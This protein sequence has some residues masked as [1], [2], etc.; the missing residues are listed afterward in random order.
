M[1][2]SAGVGC[3]TEFGMFQVVMMG[4]FEEQSVLLVGMS[5]GVVRTGE[6]GMALGLRGV[7]STA[8]G[9]ALRW[10]FRRS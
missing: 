7:R 9:Q 8:C 2:Q 10:S 5:R 4:L 3:S 1:T 6:D